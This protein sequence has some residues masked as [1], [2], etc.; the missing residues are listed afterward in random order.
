MLSLWDFLS[1]LRTSRIIRKIGDMHL[2]LFDLLS[3]KTYYAYQKGI[4]DLRTE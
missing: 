4:S 1:V 3:D 2:F